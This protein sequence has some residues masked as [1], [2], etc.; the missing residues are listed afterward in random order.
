MSPT[1]QPAQA[2]RHIAANGMPPAGCYLEWIRRTK[3]PL[4]MEPLCK[5]M[6]RLRSDG[7]IDNG[8]VTEHG[9]AMVAGWR[10]A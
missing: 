9:A 8:G 1:T 5:A 2:L 4:K 6:S 10:V 3:C 7:L